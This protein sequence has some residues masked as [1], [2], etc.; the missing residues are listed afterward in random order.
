MR[1][2]FCS[3]TNFADPPLWNFESAVFKSDTMA[4]NADLDRTST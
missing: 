1:R 3:D 4:A 2:R